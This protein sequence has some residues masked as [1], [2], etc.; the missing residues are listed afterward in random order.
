VDEIVFFPVPP[1]IATHPTPKTVDQGATVTF[2]VVANGTPPFNYQWRFNGVPLSDGIGVRGARTNTLTLT[3]VQPAQ[4][5]NYSCTVGNPAGSINT[6]NAFLTVNAVFS[7]AEALDTPNLIWATSGSSPAWSGQNLVTHDGR[8]AARSGAISDGSSCS[9]QT[10]VVGPGTV[11]F[12]WKVSSETNNDQ[13]RFYIG[14]SSTP[15][16]NISGE[17]DWRQETFPV[18]SG[19]QALK[20]SYVR[21]S[22]TS[23]GQDRGWVDE[24]V[25]T[26][27]VQGT[28]PSPD[29]ISVA[30]EFQQ[31][32]L[33][34]TWHADPTK[35]YIVLYKDDLNDTE[36]KVLETEVWY[37][38]DLAQAYDAIDPD[39]APQRFYIVTEY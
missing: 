20:F 34:L 33:A 39:L 13:L 27:S 6:T 8:D 24:V 18:P 17:V 9:I 36:W 7:L 25:Y 37:T 5:G 23:R 29:P 31:P 35:S 26:P 38:D 28:P 10:T 12:W 30:V 14:S 4:T 1:T 11:T 32:I 19:S 3:N 2:N 22:S 16:T 15:K 21:N